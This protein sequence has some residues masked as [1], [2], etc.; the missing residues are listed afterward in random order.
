MSVSDR[1]TTDLL[2]PLQRTGAL[3]YVWVLFLSTIVAA[4]QKYVQ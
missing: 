1:L 3:W 2:K 4:R